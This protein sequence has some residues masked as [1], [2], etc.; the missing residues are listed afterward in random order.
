M[1]D[2]LTIAR[3]FLN[4]ARRT[5]IFAITSRCNCRCQMCNIYDNKPLDMNYHDIGKVLN[6]LVS[7]KFLIAYFTGGEP[8]LHPDLVRI[9]EYAN[10]L[11]LVTSLTTNGTI[12]VELLE[13]LKRAGLYALSVSVDS[14]DSSF[15]E[16]VRN[17]NGLGEKQR[18]TFEAARK[19]GIKT[20]SLT[21]LGKHLSAGNIE[22]MVA[23]VNGCLGVPFGFCYPAVSRENTYR[24]GQSAETLPADEV[25]R[26]I[27]R[28]L[29]LKRKGYRIVNM[30]TYLEDALKFHEGKPTVYP[31]RA[32]EFVVYVDW[33]GDVYPCFKKK[34]LFNVLKDGKDK[35]K[36]L[37]NEPCDACLIDC[38]REPSLM[39]YLP[40][41]KLIL[42]EISDGSLTKGTIL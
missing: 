17:H 16:K 8:S 3:R 36:L 26:I 15:C 13:A 25:K 33:F 2:T 42:R 4:G 23:Y 11:G 12:S 10:G 38:F 40:S 19:L 1:T 27:E 24:L 7:H 29:V 6:F 30:A 32:G 5:A 31:C 14:W 35:Q 9:V 21:Y 20:Y 39:A 18:R 37:E 41:P 28:L 34:K 22:K